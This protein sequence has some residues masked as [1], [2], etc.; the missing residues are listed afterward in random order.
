MGAKQSRNSAKKVDESS[1]TIQEKKIQERTVMLFSKCGAS[2]FSRQLTNDKLHDKNQIDYCC[3]ALL[4]R[5]ENF[6]EFYSMDEEFARLKNFNQFNRIP[7]P[8]EMLTR[9]WKHDE[10][11][12]ILME[13]YH[14]VW[15][16]EN[17]SLFMEHLL[18]GN[19]DNQLEN[20]FTYA[21][22][23][24]TG[25]IISDFIHSDP[26]IGQP[27]KYNLAEIGG[28]RSEW[29]KAFIC[30]ENVYFIFFFCGLSDFHDNPNYDFEHEFVKFNYVFTCNKFHEINP[31]CR[32][33]FLFTKPDILQSKLKRGSI[34]DIKK[35]YEIR[36]E[37]KQISNENERNVINSIVCD[38]FAE[39]ETEYHIVNL[40]N[41]EEVNQ[42][43]DLILSGVKSRFP[44][45]S[46]C[47]RDEGKWR[48]V[49][50]R[51]LKD[52]KLGDIS[53]IAR[54]E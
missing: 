47:L 36:E 37:L 30:F 14:N 23:K 19:F 11:R 32:I 6:D 43:R 13:K 46:K 22:T 41:K 17:L 9:I 15:R 26:I 21:S 49:L 40:L 12:R 1:S 34:Y 31:N 44:F 29:K 3:H 20:P 10:M 52:S 50:F 24:T 18:N 8:R 42:V 35:N 25:V 38:F 4:S 39:H 27:I 7:R 45:I 5:M 16:F 28:S 54:G 53:I 48:Q 51:I 33:I 2:T